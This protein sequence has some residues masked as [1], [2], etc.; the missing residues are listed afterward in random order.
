MCGFIYNVASFPLLEPLFDIAGYEEEQIREILTKQFLR[1]T[2]TVLNLIPTRSGPF[3][4]PAT[5]WLATGADGK[6]NPKVTSFNAQSRRLTTAKIHQQKPRSIRSV[7]L[8][9]GFCEWQP[10]TIQ[11]DLLDGAVS[12]TI[13]K[14][15]MLIELS[16]SKL[17]LMGAVSKLRLKADG[18]PQVNTAVITLPTHPDFATIHEQSFPLLL[19][20]SE[21]TDW[22]NPELPMEH[23]SQ[24]LLTTELRMDIEITHV[25]RDLHPLSKPDNLKAKPE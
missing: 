6:I 1:P 2:D 13:Q 18:T 16:D 14:K 20:A 24:L 10:I 4:M 12:K 22:L 17:M 15:Q 19:H 5:W 8:A 23:F 9:S 25:D 7:V 3:I 21:L 11:D